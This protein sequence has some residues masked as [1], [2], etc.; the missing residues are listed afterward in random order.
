MED[1][2][3]I[4]DYLPYG[5]PDRR[6]IGQSPIAY[7]IGDTEFKILELLPRPD[8]TIK[9]DERVYIGKDRELRQEIDRVKSRINYSD[10]TATARNEIPYVITEIVKRHEER[11]IGFFNNSGGISRKYHALELLPGIGKKTMWAIVKERKRVP[12]KSFEDFTQRITVLSDPIKCITQRIIAELEGAE[13][14]KY[15][16]FVSR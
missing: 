1:Y 11:F 8:A 10:L 16:L 9:I 7:A 15:R 13:D 6:N 3:Y 12:F 2:V 4:L 14:E 5:K